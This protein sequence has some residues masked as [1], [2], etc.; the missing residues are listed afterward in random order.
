MRIRLFIAS[1]SLLCALQAQAAEPLP[2]TAQQIQNLGI[3]T[4]TLADNDQGT[5]RHLPGKVAVPAGQLQVLI[6]PV[7]GT[8][9]EVLV[10][11]GMAVKKG[12]VLARLVSPQAL[13]LQRAHAE[14]SARASQARTAL[15]RD[16]QL[17]QEG[18]IAAARLEATRALDREAAA[19]LAQT[20]QTLRLS[21][22]QPG[23]MDPVLELKA[24]M[25]GLVLE[26]LAQTGQ[27]LP[28]AT[29]IASI[30][31]LEPLWIEIQAPR[32]AAAQA[33]AGDPVAMPLLGIAGKLLEVSRAVDPVSQN[34]MLRAQVDQGAEVLSPGQ[35]VEVEITV[36]G[37]AGLAL[38]A[39]ALARHE[40]ELLVF[41]QHGSGDAT[42]F[43]A[44]PVRV[45]S[46][47]GETVM[48]EGLAVGEQVAVEGVS[49]LKGMLL[50]GTGEE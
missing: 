7:E 9:Q 25:D 21:G 22:G 48:V 40:G 18:I 44:R 46:R 34:V 38:P 33:K 49:S 41:V 32:S 6:A 11:P 27:R 30:G 2:L 17:F 39:Q 36:G 45:M 37:R 42:S 29:P 24:S 15:V 19:Q 16:E 4:Q 12:Q 43:E 35:A 10:A 31:R 13:E 1:C 26:Q 3:R 8:L 20:G 14:A 5:L 23:Q 28:A 50:N 47:I